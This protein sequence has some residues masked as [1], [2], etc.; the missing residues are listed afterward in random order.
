MA[1]GTV[2]AD[3]IAWLRRSN[4]RSRNF[5]IWC[6]LSTRMRPTT[7]CT[8][9]KRCCINTF[10]EL[11]KLL[12]STRLRP[13]S[14]TPLTFCIYKNTPRKPRLRWFAH[15]PLRL[16]LFPFTSQKHRHP[17]FPQQPAERR[18]CRGTAAT[19]AIER[20]SHVSRYTRQGKLTPNGRSSRHWKR[21]AWFAKIS[22]G[23]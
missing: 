23:A 2:S 21:S 17:P 5:A 3:G 16:C 18:L 12:S 6:C 13:D 4:Y 15:A 1:D 11:L 10:Q 8:G 14:H 20:L 9:P 22:Q 19:N 7:A